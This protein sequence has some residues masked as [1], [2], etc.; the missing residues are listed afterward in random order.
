MIVR[1]Q[2]VSVEG[3]ARS[4]LCDVA[5]VDTATNKLWVRLPTGNS[6]VLKL[7]SKSGRYEGKI[8]GLDLFVDPDNN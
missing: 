5:D 2:K 4:I 8:A 3:G 7:N 6:I 1:G